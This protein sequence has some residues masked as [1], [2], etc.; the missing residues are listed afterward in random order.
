VVALTAL[1]NQ[2]QLVLAKPN[3]NEEIKKLGGLAELTG[4]VARQ[5]HIMPDP[6]DDWLAGIAGDAGG[7][8]GD[9]VDD[10]LNAIWRADVLPFCQSAL[11]DRYPFTPDSTIDVNVADFAKLFGP[12]GLID[13]FT[14]DHLIGY[15]DT[16]TRPWK[17][18]SDFE[19]DPAA[20]AAFEQARRIRD[21]LFPGGTGPVMSFM[22]EP[23][24][25]SPTVT[26]V[27]LNLDGQSLVYF[28]NAT[29]PQPMT[30]PGKDGTGVITLAFQPIDGS[31]EVSLSETGS[32]AWLRLLR[33][34]RFTGTT[35]S[36]VYSLR[37]GTKG[38]Y[39]DFELKAASVE[40]PYNLEMFKRFSC[41]QQI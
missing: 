23:K 25:L 37:L 31:P 2:L 22:L 12:G 9:I 19:G 8:A 21:D 3:A 36:D 34:G 27:T 11:N 5:A 1:S 35:L 29:R 20:L 33:T 41:P 10:Q 26:R 18:R 39:A 40:N 14:N 28:N 17:W 30:W 13:A 4:A 32:W 6:V 38:Y 15:I 24:D 7:L 16:S